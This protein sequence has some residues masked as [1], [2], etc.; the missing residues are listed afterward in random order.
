MHPL[1]VVVAAASVALAQQVTYDSLLSVKNFS[2]FGGA[3]ITN[4]GP[5]IIPLDIGSYPSA[6]IT[7]MGAATLGGDT[8]AGDA[9]ALQALT[10]AEA[11]FGAAANLTATIVPTEL[12]GTTLTAGVYN[13]TSGELG[14]TNTAG[15]LTLDA[16]GDPNAVFVFRPG[17]TFITSTSASIVLVNGTQ[18]CNVFFIVGSSATIGTSS[19]VLGTIIARTAITM[20][21]NA[22]IVGRVVALDAATTLDSNVF[23]EECNVEPSPEPSPE[24]SVEPSHEPTANPTPAPPTAEPSASPSPSPTEEPSAEPTREPS[25]EP[26][27]LPS[28][29]PTEE[30]S[31]ERTSESH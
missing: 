31:A 26:S 21:T 16:E 27:A 15:P 29:S 9:T 14:I 20:N 6:S 1:L 18:S 30:P 5:S 28:P 25:A 8:H 13:S 7:G 19:S 22:S 17:S 4:T 24:P 2:V 12:G 3:G 10:D 23:T 11:V